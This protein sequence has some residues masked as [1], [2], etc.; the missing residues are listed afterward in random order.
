MTKEYV[1]LA[2]LGRG[3]VASGPAQPF[4]PADGMI[5][6]MAWENMAVPDRDWVV[7]N[8]VPCGCVTLLTGNGGEGKSRL[9]KQLLISC[10]VGD[11]WL[12]L[13]TKHCRTMGIFCE[14]SHDELHQRTAGIL[15]G[16]YRN[17]SDLEG[18]SLIGRKGY[19]NRMYRSRPIDAEGYFTEFYERVRATVRDFGAQLLILD[20]LYDFFGGDENNKHQATQFVGALDGL[21]TEMSGA[22][23]IVAH[24][25]GTGMMNGTGTAGSV[26][27]HNKVRS[28]LYMHRRPVEKAVLAVNPH[29]KGQLILEPMKAN[30]GPL[31]HPID[32]AFDHGQFVPK[33]MVGFGRADEPAAATLFDV[34]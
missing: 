31:Q 10:A 2:D 5:D 13:D 3:P 12:E 11:T 26:A 25:S 15:D 30:Y 21:A 24:P 7:E 6:P 22:V 23:V 8:W 19:D 16:M 4:G 20:S 34:K 27:W 1:D 18:L 17:Y 32:L 14:D 28:R 9:A 33:H 29:A